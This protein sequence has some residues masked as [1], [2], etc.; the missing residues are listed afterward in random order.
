MD[1][2]TAT[3]GYEAWLG[4]LVPLHRP[5]LDYKHRQMADRRLARARVSLLSGHSDPL[6]YDR[7][8]CRWPFMARNTISRCDVEGTSTT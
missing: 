1:T 4:G 8:T 6:T 3:R 2:I 7:R 5:D